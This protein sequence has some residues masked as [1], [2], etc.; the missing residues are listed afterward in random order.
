MIA[1]L[2][3]SLKAAQ[4]KIQL[5]EANEAAAELAAPDTNDAAADLAAAETN[6]AAE[7]PAKADNKEEVV[8]AEYI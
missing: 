3:A 8:E 2:E 1:K 7:D 4:D 6:D 5:Q